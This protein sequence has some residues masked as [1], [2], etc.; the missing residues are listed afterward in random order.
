[1]VANKNGRRINGIVKK[2][3]PLKAKSI[4]RIAAANKAKK[5]PKIQE[6]NLWEENF[7]KDW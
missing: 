1:M 6:D 4:K 3:T 2:E 5:N 7:R